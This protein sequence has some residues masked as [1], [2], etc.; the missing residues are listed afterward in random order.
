MECIRIRGGEGWGLFKFTKFKLEIRLIRDF[1][2]FAVTSPKKER[3]C[4]TELD[5][6]TLLPVPPQSISLSTLY[7][8]NGCF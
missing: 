2:S 1:F 8:L 3:R 6:D 4:C 5:H 7:T